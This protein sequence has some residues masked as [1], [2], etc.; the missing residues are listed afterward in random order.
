MFGFG[1]AMDDAEVDSIHAQWGFGLLN[2][3]LLTTM[4]M[5]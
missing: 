3:N 1:S 4:L 2:I 5:L